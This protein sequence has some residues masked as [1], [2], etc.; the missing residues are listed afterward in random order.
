MVR[1]ISSFYEVEDL[2]PISKLLGIE[3]NIEGKSAKINCPKYIEK[4]MERFNLDK[5]R[6]ENLPIQPGVVTSKAEQ[7]SR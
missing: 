2:G 4:C 6:N 7:P 5:N 3:F 1:L